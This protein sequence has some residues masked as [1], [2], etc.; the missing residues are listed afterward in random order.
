MPCQVVV[1]PFGF[2]TEP[3]TVADWFALLQTVWDWRVP[4]PP[5]AFVH[6]PWRVTTP[7]A[8]VVVDE[9]VPEPPLLV[10]KVPSRLITFSSSARAAAVRASMAKARQAT[11]A[12]LGSG[13]V[14]MRKAGWMMYLRWKTLHAA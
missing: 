3:L 1:A 5:A 6:A 13:G 11:V 4:V 8:F 14:F 7:F 2:V 9:V 10:V 12:I